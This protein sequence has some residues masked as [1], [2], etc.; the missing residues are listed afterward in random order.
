MIKTWNLLSYTMVPSVECCHRCE[1]TGLAF[2]SALWLPS[3]GQTSIWGWN[4]GGVA[5]KSSK[6]PTYVQTFNFKLILLPRHQPPTVCETRF[7]LCV[8]HDSRGSWLPLRVHQTPKIV[9]D[10][11]LGELG[12]VQVDGLGNPGAVMDWGQGCKE[13]CHTGSHNPTV[14]ERCCRKLIQIETE[15]HF[16]EQKVKTDHVLPFFFFL[17]VVNYI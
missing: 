11:F 2:K 3:P 4:Q 13:T 15:I 1:V 12:A 16:Y 10:E 9:A 17:I 6:N 5:E 14:E 8:R 7:P